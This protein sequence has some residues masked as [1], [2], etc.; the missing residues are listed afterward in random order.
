M[1]RWYQSKVAKQPILTASVTSAVLF[2]SGDVLAQQLVD[3][4]GFEKHDMARTGRMA[5]Y[6][7]A[8]FGPA[9]TTW[10]G[11]LQRNIV[12]KNAKATI[13]AR[14]AA[15]QCLFTPTHLT[16][17][18]SFMAVMEGKSPVEKLK[19][20]FIPSYKANLTIW[21]MVQG[22]NFS[23]VPLEYRLLFVNVISLGW[24]CLL[25]LINSGE[26]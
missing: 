4:K 19:A 15:D 21:P 1:L 23:I 5:L 18:L 8:I 6:G 11:F 16:C 10:F 12:L 9:A 13:I 25:S 14:V 2:G 20:S 3:R 7:G 17:F 22:F 24:N 26:K